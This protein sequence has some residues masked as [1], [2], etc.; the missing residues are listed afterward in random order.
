MSY[1][2][3]ERC[4]G[5]T[6]CAR[7]CPVSAILGELKKQHRI[8]SEIC[9]ECGVCGKLCPAGAIKDANGNTCTRIPRDQWKHPRFDYV[10]CVACTACESDCPAGCIDLIQNDKADPNTAYPVLVDPKRCLSCGLCEKVCPAGAIRM[11]EPVPDL[12]R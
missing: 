8:N 4:N 11:E 9:I 2:I 3:S 1:K 12:N 6:L 7:S 5:C 10:L